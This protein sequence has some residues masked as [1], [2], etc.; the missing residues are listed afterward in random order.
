MDQNKPKEPLPPEKTPNKQTKKTR[1]KI[2]EKISISQDVPIIKANFTFWSLYY[3][4][5]IFSPTPLFTVLSCPLFCQQFFWGKLQDW[6]AYSSSWI[7]TNSCLKKI[8]LVKQL[9]SGEALACLICVVGSNWLSILSTG[10]SHN[11]AKRGEYIYR[12]FAAPKKV[13]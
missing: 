2:Q 13:H 11:K 10:H 1:T 8:Y 3:Y 5:W 7:K 9:S 4:N 6:H 12:S